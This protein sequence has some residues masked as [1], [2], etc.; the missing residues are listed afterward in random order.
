MY[1]STIQIAGIHCLIKSAHSNLI[2]FVKTGYRHFV[3]EGKPDIEIEAEVETLPR[4]N[5]YLRSAGIGLQPD[6]GQISIIGTGEK[7][8]FRRSDF[9]GYLDM[10]TRR[11]EV[12]LASLSHPPFD[13]YLRICYSLLA[14]IHNGFLLH[15]AGVA[16][17]EKG[18]IFCGPHQTGKTT[19]SRLAPGNSTLLSDDLILIRKINRSYLVYG[20]PFYGDLPQTG[21]NVCVQTESLLFPKKDKTV[22]LQRLDPVRSLSSLLPN[23][24]LFTTELNMSKNV[25]NLCSDFCMAIPAY[26]LHFLPDNTFWRYINDIA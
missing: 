23:V 22:Y 14:G 20:T 11:G 1:T 26:E 12:G 6:N 24:L 3:S 18:Y 15:S 2:N 7:T 19:I 8:F 25:F 4:L 10:N 17:G 21:E 16:I 5:N 9:V 13:S